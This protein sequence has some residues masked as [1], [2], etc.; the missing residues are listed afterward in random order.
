MLPKTRVLNQ[1]N[2]IING[3]YISYLTAMLLLCLHYATAHCTL[4]LLLPPRCCCWCHHHATAAWPLPLTPPSRYRCMATTTDTAAGAHLVT[5]IMLLR[6]AVHHWTAVVFAA[7][8]AMATPHC[9][10]HRRVTNV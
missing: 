5:T 10:H 2:N 3:C 1:D 4:V 6:A 7:H 9:W 8:H